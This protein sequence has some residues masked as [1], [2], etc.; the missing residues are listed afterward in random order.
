LKLEKFYK[1][2]TDGLLGW[3]LQLCPSSTLS[4]ISHS[5]WKLF[6]KMENFPN[7]FIKKKTTHGWQE[8]ITNNEGGGGGQI[9]A[10]FCNSVRN[11]GRCESA[12][13]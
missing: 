4:N 7:R 2:S 13:R 12:A 9:P 8:N 10:N 5:P 11:I 3:T 6:E 1:F